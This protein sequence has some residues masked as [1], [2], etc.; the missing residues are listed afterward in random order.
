MGR[1]EGKEESPEADYD[2]SLLLKPLAAK[3]I[4]A[5]DQ[6]PGESQMPAS[7]AR[8]IISAELRAPS[9]SI[10]MPRCIFTVFSDRLSS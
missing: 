4:R 10:A 7:T 2:A 9:F 6:P 1:G 8:R 5:L 3:E